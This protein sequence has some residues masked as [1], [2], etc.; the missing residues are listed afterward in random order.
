MKYGRHDTSFTY[1]EQGFRANPVK[2]VS[3]NSGGLGQTRPDLS[4]APLQTR[5]LSAFVRQAGITDTINLKQHENR[6]DMRSDSAK[7]K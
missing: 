7:K 2:I 3:E 5:L 6:D 4:R 1:I